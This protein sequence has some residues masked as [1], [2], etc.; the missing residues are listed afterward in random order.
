[1]LCAVLFLSH[2]QHCCA[3]CAGELV[4]VQFDK[5]KIAH[6]NFAGQNPTAGLPENIRI[7]NAATHKGRSIDVILDSPMSSGASGPCVGR[8]TC[9]FQVNNYGVSYFKV[10]RGA[11][12]TFD[13]RWSFEYS[14]GS[15][16][17]TL[18]RVA[19]TWLD[20]G[21]KECADHLQMK[22]CRVYTVLQ[23]TSVL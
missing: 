5:S 1:M 13:V 19:I 12:N 14:D 15:G 6:S 7:Y 8:N 2:L 4:M 3:I 9:E 21:P 22:A 10:Q 11:A 18:S 23:P 17:A 20:M 16:A